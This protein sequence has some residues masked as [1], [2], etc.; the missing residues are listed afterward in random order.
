M[1]THTG[2]LAAYRNGGGGREFDQVHGG[3]GA[4]C[5]VVHVSKK[6]KARAE[7]GGAKFERYFADRQ[8]GEKQQEKKDAPVRPDF[9]AGRTEC[10][11]V[12]LN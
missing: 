3:D 8:G 11:R 2:R 4:V 12:G 1:R 10:W 5:G 7:E 6:V 9:H